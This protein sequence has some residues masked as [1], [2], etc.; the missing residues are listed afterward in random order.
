M[1]R[2]KEEQIVR[3]ERARQRA[4]DEG[5]ICGACGEPLLTEDEQFEGVCDR[6]Q[7][8]MNRDD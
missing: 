5:D 1:G 6:C 7:A 2:E 4:R 8:I 3:E